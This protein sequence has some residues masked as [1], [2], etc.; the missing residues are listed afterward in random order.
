MIF[1]GTEK[2]FTARVE[3]IAAGG[4]GIARPDGKSVF[5]DLSAPGDLVRFR[6]V[7]E[8]KTWARA[9]LLEILEPSPLRI[10]PLCPLYGRCGGCSLQHLTYEAQIEAKTAILR[11]AFKR[12]GGFEPPSIR[13]RSSAPF[14]YRN[15]LQFHRT[16]DGNCGL[17][18]R[19]STRP[20]ALDDC[21]VAEPGIR[22]ALKE[23]RLRGPS[24]KKRFTVYSRGKTFLVEGQTERGFVSILD[25]ELALDV[26]VFFQSNA[27]M[28]E[29]LIADL[30]EAASKTN[31]GL[32]LADIYCG[33]GTFAAFLA[34]EHS[35][36]DLVEENKAALALA[37]QNVRGSNISYYAEKDTTWVK[38]LTDNQ[39]GPWGFVIMD[40]PRQGLSGGIA[41]WL[42]A[43]GPE[44]AAYVSC[45]PATLARD[46][47]LLLDGG[48]RLKELTLYDF[49]PQTAHIE[50]LAL[51][52]R[53]GG[54]HAY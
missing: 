51:F 22:R 21:P 15:R 33:V 54:N 25:R 1:D 31:R 6:L 40:P 36:V 49:Y 23:G 42:A 19:K 28:L 7:K 10:S 32:P 4:A 46:S 16:D 13:L 48:Y 8:Y 3:R 34:A 20:V 24:D 18:E 27:A 43:N 52:C 17:M 9:E 14:E 2:T 11:D 30:R 12:I 39:R 44:L 53:E 41:K 38:T 37:R 29:L 50:T 26:K 45:D 35:G 5:I 47:R